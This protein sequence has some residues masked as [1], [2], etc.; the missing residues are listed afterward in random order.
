MNTRHFVL[1][2]ELLESRN[3]QPDVYGTGGNRGFGHEENFFP[4]YFCFS[5]RRCVPGAAR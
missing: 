3:L 2:R 4:R 5:C 1:K